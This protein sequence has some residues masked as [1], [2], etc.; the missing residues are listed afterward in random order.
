MSNRTRE[1]ASPRKPYEKPTLRRFPLV[2]D[3][4]LATGCKMATV[5]SG[6]F[7][8]FN[9]Q[10]GGCSAV[11]GRKHGKVVHADV[12]AAPGQVMFKVRPTLARS[13]V[14]PMVMKPAAT[15]RESTWPW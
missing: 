1:G 11:Q 6:G 13:H 2:A 14:L 3:E 7:Q 15:R 5:P 4:V 10:V 9:C 12:F 8:G